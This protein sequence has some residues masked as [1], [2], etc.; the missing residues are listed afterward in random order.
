MST[1]ATPARH[2]R[3]YIPRASD[4][5]PR[6][7]TCGRAPPP[8]D[9]C[10]YSRP[11]G[12]PRPPPWRTG[13]GVRAWCDMSSVGG[14]WTVVAGRRAHQPEVNFSRPLL[15]Y[16]FG[17]GDPENQH[18]L[19]LDHMHALTRATNSTLRVV[20]HHYALPAP[21]HATYQ[22]FS[23][24]S[25]EDGHRLTVEGYDPSSTAA[26]ALS[27]H[28]GAPFTCPDPRYSGNSCVEEV[29]AGWWF[30]EAPLCY[31]A[32]PTGLAAPPEPGRGVRGTLAWLGLQYSPETF[33]LMIRREGES[34]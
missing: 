24:G 15:H 5:C 28:S 2:W 18:W 20:L 6:W 22:A 12:S 31:L 21:L 19:G 29:E 23:V 8:P 32:L 33:L 11:P 27:P 14:G 4:C 17:F 16:Q 13:L 25:R 26:D 7:T 3:F 34:G 10:R 9:T 30:L 1:E